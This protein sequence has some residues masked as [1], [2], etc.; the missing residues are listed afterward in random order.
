[1]NQPFRTILCENSETTEIVEQALQ[2]L[3]SVANQLSQIKPAKQDRFSVTIFG[4]ARVQ[5]GDALY[6]D[7]KALSRELA[8]LGCDI[9]TGGGPGLMEAANEGAQDGDPDNR[10]R[11]VGVRIALPFEQGANPFVELLYTHET[12]YTRLQH[13][14]RLSHA[15]IVM[16]GGI[17]TTLELFLVWQLLQV[18]HM[19]NVPLILVGPMWR[20]LCDW[21]EKQLAP[22]ANPD[23]VKIPVCVETVHEAV[24]LLRPHIAAFPS[25]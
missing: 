11:S 8:A 23:D 6:G 10:T 17:G 14:V 16:S 5:K 22:F 19:T 1:M 20:E 24:A 12:F 4:S 25:K 13:F 7:V 15:F 18:R 21:A 9:V 2:S 3:W